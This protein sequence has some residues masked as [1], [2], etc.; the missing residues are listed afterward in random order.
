MAAISLPTLAPVL[1]GQADD[2]QAVTVPGV[3]FNLARRTNKSGAPWMWVMLAD[4]AGR[5]VPV[6]V[7]P[8]SYAQLAGVLTERAPV[9]L[10]GRVDRRGHRV[11]LVAT[12]MSLIEKIHRPSGSNRQER[13]AGPG[14][15]TSH[16]ASEEIPSMT[17]RCPDAVPDPYTVIGAPW[18][19]DGPYSSEHTASAARAVA[20]LVRYLNHAT[21]AVAALPDPVAVYDALGALSA[22]TAGLPQT[23]CQL[24]GRLTELGEDSNAAVDNLGEPMVP[25][26]AAQLAADALTDAAG[27]LA[28]TA[29]LLAAAH[30]LAGRLYLN[31]AIQ[32]GAL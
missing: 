14:S 30:T 17:H 1:T 23:L 28:D 31:T 12:D 25:R 7:F 9:L 13:P 11:G 20:E 32:G 29:R 27:Q 18:P 4:T 15:T 3:L 10:S 21:R 2:G 22:A 19:V 16:Q 26:T 8:G 6:V 24:A 5:A